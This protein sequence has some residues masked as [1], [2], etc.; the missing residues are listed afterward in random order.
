MAAPGELESRAAADL[1]RHLKHNA[2][3]G[4]GLV[5]GRA[6]GDAGWLLV[7]WIMGRSESSRARRSTSAFT[8]ANWPSRAARI[9]SVLPCSST[10]SI[11]MPRC[12]KLTSCSVSPR[13]AELRASS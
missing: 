6:R 5:V 1:E 11:S 3:P 10:V 4:R 12:S 8:V 13:R 7:Y 2:Y 9:K